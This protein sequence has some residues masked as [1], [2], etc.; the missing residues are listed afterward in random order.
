MLI[1]ERVGTMQ[2]TRSGTW[3]HT[4]PPDTQGAGSWAAF[5]TR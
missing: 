1:A 5:P 3:T 4:A 2:T